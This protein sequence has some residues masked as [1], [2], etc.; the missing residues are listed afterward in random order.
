LKQPKGDSITEPTFIPYYL[1]ELTPES[2][3]KQFSVALARK[4]MT[5]S[6]GFKNDLIKEE[7]LKEALIL[8]THVWTKLRLE[9]VLNESNSDDEDHAADFLEENSEHDVSDMDRKEILITATKLGWERNPEPTDEELIN[10]G[11]PPITLSEMHQKATKQKRTETHPHRY[12]HAS[13]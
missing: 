6:H 4:L 10:Y 2:T 9:S 11:E 13:R 8:T 1:M 5:L 12:S 3:W 7:S